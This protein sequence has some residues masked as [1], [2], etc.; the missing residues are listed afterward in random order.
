M[1]LYKIRCISFRIPGKRFKANGYD[2]IDDMFFVC[3]YTYFLFKIIKKGTIIFNLVF[4]QRN[5]LKRCIVVNI[6]NSDIRA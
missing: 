5:I 6:Q 1:L 3:K 4:S 2:Y